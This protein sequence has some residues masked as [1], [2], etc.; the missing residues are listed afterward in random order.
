MCSKKIWTPENKLMRFTWRIVSLQVESPTTGS[1]LYSRSG[2][3]ATRWSRGYPKPQ[4]NSITS[5]FFSSILRRGFFNLGWVFNRWQNWVIRLML[6]SDIP[7]LD[8][9]VL[10]DLS[11]NRDKEQRQLDIWFCLARFHVTPLGW[12]SSTMFVASILKLHRLCIHSVSFIRQEIE[13]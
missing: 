3:C 2:L 1:D 4:N 13:V 9:V 11:L 6:A 10:Y 7:F 8:Q 12:G 5:F